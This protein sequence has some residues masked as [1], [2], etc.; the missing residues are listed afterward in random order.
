MRTISEQFVFERQE[1]W[2]R[3]R[4]IVLKFS[5]RSY[6]ALAPDETAE[7]PALYRQVCTD[8]AEA[9]MLQLSHDVIGYLN[10]L[11]GQAHKG[12]YNFPVLKKGSLKRF[13]L[14]ELPQ[15]FYQY[16]VFIL[17][18]ALLFVLPMLVSFFVINANPGY[19]AGIVGE[20]LLNSMETSYADELTGQGSLG[21]G[22]FAVSYYIQHNTS[23]AFASFAA[24]I[25]AGFGTIYFLLY[26]GIVLGTIAGYVNALGYGD[27]FWKFVTAHS[28]LELTG[29]IL[30]GAAGLFLGYSIVK[31][32]KY[33][34]RDWLNLQMKNIL[35]LLTPAVFCIGLAAVIEGNLSPSLVSFTVRIIVASSSL[36]LLVFYFFIFKLW[37]DKNREQYL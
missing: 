18:S 19:A 21:A 6:G 13:F 4:K 24:G 14:D 5:K 22:T 15:L 23:I 8:L 20:S 11:V 30:A 36:L 34:R 31:A 37:R 32:N 25:L 33:R 9:R 12:L 26:N 35:K 3:L 27:H 16:W 1:R 28:V 10:N 2:L 29:L 17:A 7:F